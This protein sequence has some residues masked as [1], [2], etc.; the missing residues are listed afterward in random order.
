ML[1]Y[2]ELASITKI[3]GWAFEKN[4]PNPIYI[5]IFLDDKLADIIIA[6]K[7]RKDIVDAGIHKSENC[8]FDY[9]FKQD[10]TM[11][12]I[13][14]VIFSSTGE[15]LREGIVPIFNIS[16]KNNSL[17]PN[18][19][20]FFIHIPKTAGTSFRLEMIKYHG[21]NKVFP[22]TQDLINNKEF[23]HTEEE[24]ITVLPNERNSIEII[25]G[26]YGFNIKQKY[27][28][29][30]KTIVFLRDPI[31]RAISNLKHL[32]RFST[33]F[34]DKK[35]LE[36]AKH[37]NICNP[38]IYN[39]QTAMLWDGNNINDKFNLEK[40]KNNLKNIEFIGITE[41]YKKSIALANKT[42]NWKL[43]QKF[44]ANKSKRILNLQV[45]TKLIDFL[46]THNQ[47]DIELHKIAIELFNKDCNNK[48]I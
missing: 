20:Y 39:R 11:H 13:L 42:F 30:S 2:L 47:I 1:G 17:V 23:Y 43:K 10:I 7:P 19:N 16:N 25:S 48:N 15:I 9:V 38:E 27:F 14:K 21:E 46:T 32:Q 29:N 28:I 12:N 5:S 37:G 41:N 34:K 31:Q 8:G 18:I 26:H 6:D 45:N 35:L 33:L 36:I 24:L 44:F 22:N 3:Q 40:A 4:N